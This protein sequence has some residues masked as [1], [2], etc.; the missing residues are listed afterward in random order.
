M[1][2]D[3]ALSLRFLVLLGVSGVA[4]EG[5]VGNRGSSAMDRV[6]QVVCCRRKWKKESE[7]AVENR[8]VRE[9]RALENPNGSN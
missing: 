4:F 6:L 8:I 9:V 3:G 1:N 5:M 2:A 7:A